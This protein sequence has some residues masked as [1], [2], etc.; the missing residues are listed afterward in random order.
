LTLYTQREKKE[1][2][3]EKLHH[4]HKEKK[5]LIKHTTQIRGEE[6]V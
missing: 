4:A 1:A 6:K 3:K 2:S 5:S